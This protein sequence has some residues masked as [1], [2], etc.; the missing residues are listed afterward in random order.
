MSDDKYV[1]EGPLTYHHRDKM[2]WWEIRHGDEDTMDSDWF[3]E[4]PTAGARVR[5]TVEIITPRPWGIFDPVEGR[6]WP[7]AFQTREEAQDH[8]DRCKG[9][10]STGEVRERPPT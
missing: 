1:F 3:K 2:C 5:L 6:W 9:P 7:R 4:L 8:Y 10:G